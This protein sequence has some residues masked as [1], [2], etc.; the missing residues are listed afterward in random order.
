ME[1]QISNS[2]TRI[3]VNGLGDIIFT[4]QAVKSQYLLIAR[5]L[6]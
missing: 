3:M 5:V 1:I 2:P 6:L 4:S